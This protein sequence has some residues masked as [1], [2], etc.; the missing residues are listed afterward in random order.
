LTW[1]IVALRNSLVLHSLDQVPAQPSMDQAVL[2]ESKTAKST[3][4]SA[5]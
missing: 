4:C 3:A 1:S 2:R 5:I